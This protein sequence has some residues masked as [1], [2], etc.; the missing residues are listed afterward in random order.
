MPRP[1]N[2]SHHKTRPSA[3]FPVNF[4]PNTSGYNNMPRPENNT[5]TTK[6]VIQ[7]LFLYEFA[8][9]RPLLRI[10]LSKIQY[11]LQPSKQG[12]ERNKGK[13]AHWNFVASA[14]LFH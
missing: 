1:I 11:P 4:D 7:A 12:E 3:L 10:N 13:M 5:V 6:R 9:N 14:S 2:D 8:Q